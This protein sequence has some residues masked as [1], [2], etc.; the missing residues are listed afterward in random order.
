[1]TKLDDQIVLIT[2]GANG[3]GKATAELFISK[4]MKVIIVDIDNKI[5]DV[6]KLI[7]AYPLLFDVSIENNWKDIV[8]KVK[9]EFHTLDILVNNAATNGLVDKV[10][11]Q[12]PEDMSLDTWKRIHKI[13]LDS[14]FLGCKYGI[15]LMKK[16]AKSNAIVNVA[17]RSGIV[18]VPSLA[19]YASSKAAIR[20]YTKSVALYCAE[21][22]Y[23][24]RCNTV[25]PAA[26]LTK[27]WDHL[28][29]DNQDCEKFSSVI[30]L[31]RMGKA[32]DVAN[33]IFYLC[34]DKADFI[35]GTELIVD[36]GILAGSAAAPSGQ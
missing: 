22:H 13:N 19:A 6:A 24:I 8:K 3:I 16:N 15:S 7:G 35:T 21:K 12:N 9:K 18:G 25:S 27:M 14:V 1:M 4:G 30:P 33:A 10:S 32:I 17:S 2:G 29:K 36:G 5:F 34:S 28:L 23:N 20:N 11:I 31:R 26:I